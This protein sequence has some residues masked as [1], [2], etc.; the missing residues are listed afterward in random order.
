MEVIVHIGAPKT[1]TTAIQHALSSNRERLISRGI[2]YPTTA[3]S[4][5]N[6][7]IL[8]AGLVDSKF[9]LGRLVIPYVEKLGRSRDQIFRDEMECIRKQIRN[10]KPDRLL[11]STETLFKDISSL[12]VDRLMEELSVGADQLKFICYVRNPADHYLSLAQQRLKH[13]SQF[14]VPKPSPFREVLEGFVRQ[15]GERVTIRLYDSRYLVEGDSVKDIINLIDPG[16]QLQRKGEGRQNQTVSAEI[17]EII[18]DYRRAHY[19]TEDNVRKKDVDKLRNSLKKLEANLWGVRK[20]RLKDFVRQD[21]IRKSLGDINWL[22]GHTGQAIDWGDELDGES[23]PA[24]YPSS[25]KLRVSDVCEVDQERKNALL[26]HFI[27]KK[28]R[29]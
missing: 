24:R 9:P 5:V 21:V 25:A 16:C 10:H 23:S 29:K 15:F 22:S 27:A 3:Y 12:C 18:Q 13:S 19:P 7:T 17:M 20:P 14:K 6:H 8:T 2:L 11:L 28:L 1:G 4:D 26:M